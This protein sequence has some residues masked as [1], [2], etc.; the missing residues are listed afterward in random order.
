MLTMTEAAEALTAAGYDAHVWQDR[1]IYVRQDG[2]ELGYLIESDLDGG[3][4]TCKQVRR[5]GAIARV[6]REANA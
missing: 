3:T 2:R 5:S 1:R 4:G 6:L